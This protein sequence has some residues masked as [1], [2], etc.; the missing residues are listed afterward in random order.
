MTDTVAATL[1]PRQRWCI[2]TCEYPPLVGGVS[3]HTLLLASAL[4]RA[5]DV[6][7]VWTPPGDGAPPHVAGVTVHV[8]PSLFKLDSLR[9]LR[10][11]LKE[12]LPD[13]RVLVQYVPTGFGLWMMN[14]PFAMLLYA[15]R[16][17]GLDVYFHEVGFIISQEKRLRRK[18]VGT[19]HLVMNWLSVRSARRIFVAIPEW[20]R[21]LEK[22]GVRLTY[23]RRSLTWV[24]VPSNVPDVV[25]P[26][27]TAEIRASLLS[28]GG[29]TIIGHFGTFG[30]FH[31]AI[32]LPAFTRVLDEGPDR[33]VLLVGRNSGIM[34]D[35]LIARRPELAPRIRATGGVAAEAVS[36]HLS[37]CDILLQP[38]EDGA[39]AR[40]GSL[41]AG[42]ALGLPIVSN[43]GSVTGTI[44]SSRAAV[45]LVNSPNAVDL[46]AGVDELLATPTL[47][48]SLGA[49]AR[50]L[51][52]QE[53][54]LSRGVAILRG[55]VLLTPTGDAAGRV[56]Q[57]TVPRVLMFHTTLP[58]PGRKPGGVEIAVHRLAN[59]LHDLGVP[60]TVASLTDAPNDA[61]YVHRRLFPWFP[62]LRDYL[63]GRLVLLPLLLNTIRFGDA[64]VVHFHG[65]DWFVFRRSRAT[66]RTMH[67][68]ALREAQRATRW[69]RSLVQYMI[70]P[71]ERLSAFM[72]TI[73]VAVSRDTASLLRIERVVGNG[74]D[75]TLFTPGVKSRSPLVLYLGTWGGRK[76]GKWMYDLFTQ[77]IVP[78]HPDAVLHFMADVTPPAHPRVRPDRFPNDVQLAAAYRE[79]WVFALPSTYEGFGIPYLEAMASG[80]PVIASPNS[81]AS[82]LL[83]GGKDGLLVADDEFAPALLR[84]LDD[85]SE[86]ERLAAH[87][88]S[89]SSQFAWPHIAGEYLNIYREAVRLRRG[90]NA[91]PG[92][93]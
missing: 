36:E 76:R 49:A 65:D 84:L 9:M 6:V 92:V 46:A 18:L 89:R 64:D 4:A 3:D 8:L 23:G 93:P 33:I 62:S 20:Q 70:Y 13:T 35:A 7:D 45:Y 77:R 88:L 10:R 2:I 12:Q 74:V 52:E 63:V 82:E 16:K 41:M 85:A 87:G 47:R 56:T 40:R 28:G 72:A 78:Q 53:F 19:M 50:I 57:L 34:R 73:P 83:E 37:A 66:V 22:L 26:A 90:T 71:F 55:A 79:A 68:S 30:R 42:L 17:R 43:R 91:G 80:T 60:V 51:H 24:P 48:A 39:S 44:W 11:V 1:P 59:A 21:R 31:T 25:D 14:V 69:Q 5:G 38:Y 15:Q 32:L 54:S 29:N 75:P 58:T 27:V 86:R 61:R 81:G 67:G